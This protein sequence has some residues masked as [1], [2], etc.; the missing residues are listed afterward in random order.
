MCGACSD[1]DSNVFAHHGTLA[2][3]ESKKKI[4]EAEQADFV[5]SWKMELASVSDA[6]T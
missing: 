5:S 3:K 6:L 2:E 4:Q 1:R